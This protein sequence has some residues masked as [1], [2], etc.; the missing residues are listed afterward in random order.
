MKRRVISISDYMIL[1]EQISIAYS[2]ITEARDRDVSE[3]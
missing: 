3:K 2:N 1:Q